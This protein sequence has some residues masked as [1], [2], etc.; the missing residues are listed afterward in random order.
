VSLIPGSH[1][2]NRQSLFKSCKS[3]IYCM[4]VVHIV[5]L[6]SIILLFLIDCSLKTD[7]SYNITDSR[8]VAWHYISEASLSQVSSVNNII[9]K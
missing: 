4:V 3:I 2:D 6:Y 9:G 8:L 7:S 5:H 1:E